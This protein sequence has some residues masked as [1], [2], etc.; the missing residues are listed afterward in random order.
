MTR[1][2]LILG[3]APNA[4]EARAWPRGAVTDL[5]AINNAWRIRDDWD[6]FIHPD[7][8]PADK[9]PPDPTGQVVSSA[10]Y[11]PVQNTYGGFV[12][13]GGTMAFTAGYWALGTLRPDV[14]AFFGCDM[15]YAPSG[16]THF[17]GIGAADP[18]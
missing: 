5:V 11:V 7:D 15:V 4:V 3:S 16:N 17:Y 14:M 2:V 12:Y 1:I 9:M 18:L 10:D 8:L 6:H 13:A